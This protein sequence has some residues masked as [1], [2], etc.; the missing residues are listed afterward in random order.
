MQTYEDFAEF[1][2]EWTD[3]EDWLLPKVLEH[4]ASERSD[5]GWLPNVIELH[6]T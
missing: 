4:Q 2:L 1:T 3:Q 5:E 6:E